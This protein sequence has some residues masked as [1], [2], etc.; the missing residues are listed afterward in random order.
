[1][2]CTCTALRIG[3]GES[4]HHVGVHRQW[5]RDLHGLQYHE[6]ESTHWARQCRLHV[7]TKGRI[8]VGEGDCRALHIFWKEVHIL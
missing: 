2:A 4:I 8:G 5:R 6:A 3:I 1:M 7:D